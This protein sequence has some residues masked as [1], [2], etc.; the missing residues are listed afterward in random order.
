MAKPQVVPHGGSPAKLGATVT[1]EGV[2]PYWGDPNAATLLRRRQQA[3]R[4]MEISLSLTQPEETCELGEMS[5]EGMG[6]SG[7]NFAPCTPVD[8]FM[9]N[10]DVDELP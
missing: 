9:G 8:Q 6:Q 4:V 5:Q 2:A 10:A 1:A 7:A 3:V